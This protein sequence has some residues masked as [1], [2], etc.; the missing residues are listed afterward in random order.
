MIGTKLQT[1][2]RKNSKGARGEIA[3]F[4]AFIRAFGALGGEA[5]AKEYHGSRYQVTFDEG[6]GAGRAVPR[7][8]LCDVMIVSYPKGDPWAARVTF[9][10]AKVAS[11]AFDCSWSP[12]SHAPYRFRANLEQWD[13]LS[14]RPAI[15][16]AT[17]TFSP[18]SGLLKDALLPS[19]GSFGVFYPS[20]GGFEFAYF[21][22]NA[23]TP[24]K[25]SHGRSGTL[26]WNSPISKIRKVGSHDEVLG[27]CCL[28]YFGK[29]I[30]KGYIGTPLTLLLNGTS[31]GEK[32]RAWVTQVLVSLRN[33]FPESTLPSELLEG[34]ELLVRDG[35]EHGSLVSGGYSTPR[36][37]VLIRT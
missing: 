24:L 2:F 32:N 11:S 12:S 21:V 17:A 25:N 28:K 31:G 20:A 3:L 36:A 19:V 18:P 29:S 13:L 16:P 30:E 26:K 1:A 14:N 35:D 9:N 10:Q 4:R 5:L 7:C 8:E 33:E 22:A 27:T 15:S 23:L 34:L 6:R 37:V